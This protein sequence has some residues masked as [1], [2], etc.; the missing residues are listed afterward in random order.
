MVIPV[1]TMVEV[2][3][4]K[5]RRRSRGV[6]LWRGRDRRSDSTKHG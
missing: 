6:S 5:K 3:G 4:M 2:A 1:G